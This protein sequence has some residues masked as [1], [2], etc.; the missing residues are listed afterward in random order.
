VLVLATLSREA[1]V[2]WRGKL[3]AAAS[4]LKM[5][6]GAL[7]VVAGLLTLSG[8]D[9]TIQTALENILPAWMIAT[10]TRI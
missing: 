9:R 4:S 8:V 5:A 6:L 7:L 10:A 1:L 2:R 3:L